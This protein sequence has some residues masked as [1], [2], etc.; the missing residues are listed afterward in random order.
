MGNRR[1]IILASNPE[2]LHDVEKFIEQLS[3]EFHL[4]NTYFG[5]ILIA[6]TEAVK[7]GILHGNKSNPS[8]KL[9]LVLEVRK[10]GLVFI[11]VDQGEGFNYKDYE[12]I[13]K[14]INSDQNSAN[15]MVL[16]HSL[17]D[18]VTFLENGRK[19]ELLFRVNGIEEKVIES[20]YELMQQ[21]FKVKESMKN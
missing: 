13:D 20:R 3:D 18:E 5:N 8:K 16:I 15:G 10:E 14:L 19:L 17:C 21:F 7:N 11:I 2:S 1:E 6:V 9:S 12:D 4:N